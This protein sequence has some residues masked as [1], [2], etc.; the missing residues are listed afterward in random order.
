MPPGSST[1]ASRIA[2]DQRVHC[3]SWLD[4]DVT[5]LGELF[6]HVGDSAVLLIFVLRFRSIAQCYGGHIP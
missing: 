4:Y 3:E 6:L 2:M 5:Y 1:C